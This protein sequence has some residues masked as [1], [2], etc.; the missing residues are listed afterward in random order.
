MGRCVSIVGGVRWYIKEVEGLPIRWILKNPRHWGLLLKAKKPWFELHLDSSES[1]RLSADD[2]LDAFWLA[3]RTAERRGFAGVFC[4]SWFFD[5]KLKSISPHLYKLRGDEEWAI[6]F[7]RVGRTEGAF[8][9][10]MAKS[11]TRRMLYASGQYT[12]TEYCMVLTV[13]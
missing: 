8:K 13:D 4:S 12:P 10:A 9:D 1:N 5:P 6:D 7:L 2:Y 11:Q 3:L